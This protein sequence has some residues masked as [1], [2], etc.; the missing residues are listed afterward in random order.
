LKSKTLMSSLTAKS[1]TM[2]RKESSEEKVRVL[3]PALP[4]MPWQEK[5]AG[6]T[7]AM[8]RYTENPVLKRHPIPCAQS[9]Y[10]SAVIP[11]EAG[12]AGVFRADYANGIPYLHRGFSSDGMHWDIDHQAIRFHGGDPEVGKM[13]YAYD[14][15]VCRIDNTYYIIWCNGYH[16]GPTI[17]VAYTNDFQ[18]FHQLENAFLPYNRNGV[19]FPR[20]INGRFAMLSRPSDKGHTPFGDIYYSESPDLCFWGKHRFVM[21]A[22]GQWWQ[23]VKIG[24][25]SVPIETNQGWLMFYHGVMSTC[26]GFV[27][28]IGA[29]LMDLDKPWKVLYRSN[30]A[31]LSPEADYETHGHVANIVFPCAALVDGA[32]GRIALYYGA[33]DTFTCIAFAQVDEIV[34]FLKVNSEVF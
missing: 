11:F 22:G 13:E 27:Y 18:S 17:G 32:T 23:G 16:G 19:L 6:S 30:Q 1:V 29:T 10:N 2:L 31:L 26:N 20:K 25:G 8:W 3:A 14:P 9:I 5:P 7:E 21:G 33:A 15:R 24:A 4:D 12:Y 28:S 34:Q